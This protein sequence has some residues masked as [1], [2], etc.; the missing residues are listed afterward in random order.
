[1]KL[2]EYT[3][4]TRQALATILKE[5]PFLPLNDLVY[6]YLFHQIITFELKPAAKLGEAKIAK[7]LGISRSPVHMAV[8]RLVDE[9][10]AVK[11]EGKGVSVANFTFS[12]CLHLMR[13]RVI[14]ESE[15]GFF[16]VSNI[17]DAQRTQLNALAVQISDLSMQSDAQGFEFCDFA[18]H[19]LLM[20]CCANPYLLE[21]YRCLQPRLLYFRFYLRYH[22][23]D[24]VLQASVREAVIS[25]RAI[26]KAIDLGL[27]TVVRDELERH[28]TAS[29]DLFMKWH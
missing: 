4:L 11:D 1:M 7:D 3:P 10:L 17:T 13:A 16:A 2:L 12:D 8:M 15:A 23:G 9:K 26:C 28:V 25:H 18:F 14:L 20:E 19:N 29:K 5:Q 6:D 27:P 22:F 24:A 21:M